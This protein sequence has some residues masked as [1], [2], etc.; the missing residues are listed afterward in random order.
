M[1]PEGGELKSLTFVGFV[2]NES[3]VA[4]SV[5]RIDAEALAEKHMPIVTTQILTA[6]YKGDGRTI[7]KAGVSECF[8]A[9]LLRA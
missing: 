5:Y 1:K 9:F 7:G 8:M 4:L 2:Y 3:K 6:Q